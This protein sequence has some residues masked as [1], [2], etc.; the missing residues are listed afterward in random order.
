MAGST[1]QWWSANSSLPVVLDSSLLA[2]EWLLST[3]DV[4][5]A[6]LELWWRATLKQGFV[7]FGVVWVTPWGHGVLST[8][9]ARDSSLTAVGLLLSC[10]GLHST[11]FSELSLLAAEGL[12]YG[13][14]SWGAPLQ[15]FH[16]DLLQFWLGNPLSF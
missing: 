4:Q 1:L 8:F 3:C 15:L 7:G 11:Y 14:I 5:R 6:P 9:G 12:L 16:G 13:V 2:A 10:E